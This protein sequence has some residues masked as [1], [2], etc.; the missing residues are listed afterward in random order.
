MRAFGC[1][2]DFFLCWIATSAFGSACSQ[3]HHHR[4]AAREFGFA[5]DGGIVM[6]PIDGPIR[7]TASARHR[8][9]WANSILP[10]WVALRDEVSHCQ[11]NRGLVS[12]QRECRWHRSM[13]AEANL[14]WFGLPAIHGIND[15]SVI[16]AQDVLPVQDELDKLV[17]DLRPEVERCMVSRQILAR[18]GRTTLSA[19]IGLI[20]EDG[21]VVA[22]LKVRFK[23]LGACVANSSLRRSVRF[24]GPVEV[25]FPLDACISREWCRD[26]PNAGIDP[27]AR[28]GSS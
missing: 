21:E 19:W 10:E 13:A 23:D 18:F 24:R 9:M 25:W 15:L 4:D 26:Y 17:D 14:V 2:R 3:N 8:P 16:G 28:Q 6:T 22:N 20:W 5:L 27:T 11:S 12:R 1:A 7:R